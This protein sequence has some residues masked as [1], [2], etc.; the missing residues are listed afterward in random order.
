MATRVSHWIALKRFETRVRDY[1]SNGG[2]NEEPD[3]GG[4]SLTFAGYAWESAD[5]I[6]IC[7]WMPSK[8]QSL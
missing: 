4:L 5:Q 6:R 2:S 3:T 7:S 1:A 8:T